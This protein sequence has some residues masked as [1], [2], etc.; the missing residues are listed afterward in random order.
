MPDGRHSYFTKTIEALTGFECR[1][2]KEADTDT[3][4]SFLDDP[5]EMVLRA[6]LSEGGDLQLSLLTDSSADDE[7]G[8]VAEVHAESRARARACPRLPAGVAWREHGRRARLGGGRA[9]GAPGG[10][11]ARTRIPGARS[12]QVSRALALSASLS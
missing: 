3:I 1:T 10:R 7:A 11:D 12:R 6:I 2:L 5:S 4:T 9:W 8:R